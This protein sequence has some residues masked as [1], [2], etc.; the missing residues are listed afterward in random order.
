M[1]SI[2]CFFFLFFRFALLSLFTFNVA[3]NGLSLRQA[4]ATTTK[5]QQHH[6]IIAQRRQTKSQPRELRNVKV[7]A[8]RGGGTTNKLKPKYSYESWCL[9]YFSLL[10]FHNFN[11]AYTHTHTHTQPYGKHSVIQ[12][13]SH[14]SHPASIENQNLTLKPQ[15]RSFIF[16]SSSSSL[17]LSV[18]MYVCM[19]V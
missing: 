6:Q 1:P 18:V 19:C 7:T 15:A 11:E 3:S 5:Q 12:S 14:P 4:A 9:L 8:Y 17:Y 16:S 10:R 13:V 2:S